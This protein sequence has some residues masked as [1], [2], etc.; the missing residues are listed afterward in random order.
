MS[1]SQG[2]IFLKKKNVNGESKWFEDGDEENDGK[3]VGKIE[4]GK[5]NG[6]GTLTSPDGDKYEGE[7]K[8]GEKH[9][10]G[11]YNWS[12]GK[13][14]VGEWKNGK[15]WNLTSYDKYGNILGKW[16]NGE[17]MTNS[18]QKTNPIISCE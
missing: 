11:T 3:Y 14:Y 9:G 5:P 15:E 1:T 12:Y 16:V 10:Q 2:V 4:N 18:P 6:H 7:W 8:D 13:K 17:Q